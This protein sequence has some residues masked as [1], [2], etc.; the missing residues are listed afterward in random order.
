MQIVVYGYDYCPHTRNAA[1]LAG[2]PILPARDIREC[3]DRTSRLWP[4]AK[5]VRDA[6][7]TTIPMCFDMHR[8][9]SRFI[10]GYDKLA[11]YMREKA[12]RKRS[13]GK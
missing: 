4:L 11:V 8:R 1:A 10:G 6:G 5:E 12:R 9:K 3:A 7:H 13:T 2:V